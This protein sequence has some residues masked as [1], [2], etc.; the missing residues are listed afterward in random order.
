MKRKNPITRAFTLVELLV[1]IA[2]I[3]ILIALLLP[4]VQAA[5]EAARRMQCTNHIKQYA[6]A[7]HNYH[8]VYESF[9][10][11]ISTAKGGRNNYSVNF[12][13]MPFY[14]QAARYDAINAVSGLE[15]W[16]TNAV[17]DSGPIATLLCPSDGGDKSSV[18]RASNYMICIGDGIEDFARGR[19]APKTDAPKGISVLGRSVF[20]S[21]RYKNSDGSADHDCGE[22]RNFS[23]IID[24]TSN[25]IAVSEAVCCTMKNSRKIKGGVAYVAWPGTAGNGGPI[26]K[27]GLAVLSDPNDRSAFK[28]SVTS[29]NYGSWFAGQ[30]FRGGCLF[31]GRGPYSVFHTVL[32]PNSPSCSANVSDTN[33]YGIYSATSN[34]AGGVNTGLFDGSVRFISDTIDTNGSNLGQ[35][36]SGPSPYGLWGAL[37]SPQGSEAKSL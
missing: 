1:V 17:L 35:V 32:P 10:A 13:L 31:D 11:M 7:L 28:S 29:V 18:P 36:E 23:F 8:D 34:H 27:C 37:G 6:L 2:I 15:T 21:S 30:H 5:R 26:G 20:V 9:P 3:G 12:I 22:W 19:G 14:E 4:A 24:G 25:T 33:E 16:V